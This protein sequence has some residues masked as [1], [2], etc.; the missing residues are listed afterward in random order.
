MYEVLKRM[1]T[2]EAK[3]GFCGGERRGS[4]GRKVAICPPPF[5]LSVTQVLTW[6]T[7]CHDTTRTFSARPQT[8]SIIPKFPY[9]YRPINIL[10]TYGHVYCTT[11]VDMI[12]RIMEWHHHLPLV[13]PRAWPATPPVRWRGPA[14][15]PPCRPESTGKLWP[16]PPRSPLPRPRPRPRPPVGRRRRPSPSQAEQDVCVYVEEHCCCKLSRLLARK[17]EEGGARI[18]GNQPAVPQNC[19]N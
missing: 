13:R 16:V 19:P 11:H 2:L 5:E 3:N 9:V 8:T 6:E 4:K 12:H 14:A 18:R 1:R 10:P 15:S 7:I 17:N